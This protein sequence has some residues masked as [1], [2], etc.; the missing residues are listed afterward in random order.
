[1]VEGELRFI[2]VQPTNLSC[3]HLPKALR[4]D[5]NTLLI[6]AVLEEK[7]RVWPLMSKPCLIKWLVS[8]CNSTSTHVGACMSVPVEESA[9]L[10]VLKIVFSKQIYFYDFLWKCF[11]ISVGVMNYLVFFFHAQAG[12]SRAETILFLATVN[13]REN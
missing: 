8:V 3:Q 12:G 4:N 13:Y 2:D 6:K 10:P 7:R 11:Y 1:M 9:F 5:S